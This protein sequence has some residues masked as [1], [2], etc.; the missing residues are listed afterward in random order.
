MQ[1]VSRAFSTAT[2]LAAAAAILGMLVTATPSLAREYNIGLNNDRSG[3]TQ[4]VG[5][6]KGEAYHDYI[7]LFNSK[8]LLGA[9]NSIRVIE[10]DHGYNVPRGLEAYERLKNEGILI[11]AE[12]STPISIALTPKVTEDE[13]VMITYGFG[14]GE[15]AYGKR[16]PWLFMSSASYASQ[17]ATAIQYIEKY[18]KTPM[19]DLKIAFLFWDSPAGRE[20]MAIIE[21]LSKRLGFELR[22]FAVPPPGI[23]MRPQVLDIARRYKADYVVEHV[24]GRAGGV[25]FKEFSRVGFPMDRLVGLTWVGAEADIEVAGWD[26]AQ[27]FISVQAWPAGEHSV[28]EEIRALKRKL[29]QKPSPMMS[30]TVYY[31]SGLG[32]AMVASEG[33]RR[34]VEKNGP[35]ITAR[36]V[37]DAFETFRQFDGDGGFLVPVTITEEDH[38]GGGY[39]AVYQVQGK[40]FKTLETGMRGYRDTVTEYLFSAKD[41]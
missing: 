35:N 23:E 36:H 17:A 24:F 28:Y 25:Q 2:A 22:T 39:A 18:S 9:G 26:A 14:A 41:K 7:Q 1:T 15:T 6:P 4:N 16:F 38:E 33:I 19:K 30:S 31:N 10:I 21:A 11:L 29:G 34:A 3:P 13:I 20:P 5:V 40:G 27:G 32:G 37:R 8:N 12:N